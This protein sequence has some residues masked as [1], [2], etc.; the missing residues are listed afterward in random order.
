MSETVIRFDG[1]TKRYKT[2]TAVNDVSLEVE[3]GSFFALLGPNGAGKTT[4]IRMLMGFS[5]PT[6]G[7]V[8]IEGI[9][10][11]S[12]TARRG[13][14]YLA[15]NHRIAPYLNATQYLHRQAALLGMEHQQAGTEIERVLE[16]V[17]M[18]SRKRDRAKAYSKGMTQRVGLAAA[19][20]GGPD[21][22]VLDEPVSGL[23]PI[24]IRDIRRILEG[25]RSEGVTM[26]LN[27][28]LLSEVEKTCNTAA[29]IR[30]GE[31]V[32]VDRIEN[33]TSLGETL[34][35]VF[36]RAIEGQQ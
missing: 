3:K 15:E 21:I 7:S 36:V 9:P 24:G 13:I 2:I 14:G 29:I 26:L 22:L 33:I 20:L 30:D 19:L 23:D 25:L 5:S 10:S 31:I 18:S 11:S 4:L 34:E 27:S 28:H 17:G 8:R 16:I 1:I 35:D 6:R 32:L 12:H